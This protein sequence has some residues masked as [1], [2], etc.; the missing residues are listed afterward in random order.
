MH[1]VHLPD[2]GPVNGIKY[3]AMGIM[4][5]VNDYNTITT[6]EQQ[7][8]IDDFF[9]GLMWEIDGFDPVVEMVSYGKLMMMVD[10]KNRWVYKGSVTTPPCATTVYWNVLR[11]VYPLKQRHL[12]QFQKQLRRGSLKSNWRLI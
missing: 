12:D 3:A 9:D 2:G 4:F 7:K 8:I 1:T 6:P 5:S 11:S 10:N